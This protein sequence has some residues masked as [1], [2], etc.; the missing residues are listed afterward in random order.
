MTI[1]GTTLVILFGFVS[2]LGMLLLQSRRPWVGVAAFLVGALG[3][4][5]TVSAIP[6]M[7]VP[8]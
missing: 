3:I 4:V 1:L 2:I 5:V 8:L 6:S 7:V